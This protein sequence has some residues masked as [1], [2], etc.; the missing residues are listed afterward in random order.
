[1]KPLLPTSMNDEELLYS[2]ALTRI[3][4]LGLAGMRKLWHACGNATDIFRRRMELPELVTGSDK[5]VEALD[6]PPA[7]ERARHELEFIRKNK[8]ACLGYNDAEYPSRL[9][10]CGDAPTLL[11]YKGNTPLNQ[12]KVIN[13]VG[14]RHATEYG[15]EICH[16][17]LRDL[18]QLCPEVLIVSGLAYGI[19]IH[20]HRAALEY[21]F[22]TIGVLAHGLDRIYPPS[23]RH[24]AVQMVQQ[25]GLLTEFM[26]ETN[27]DR[28]NF[29][30][31]NRIV[32]SMCDA[33]IVVESAAKGGALITADL[34]EGYH[35]DCFAFPGR[36]YDPYSQ[37]CN[38]LIR[39]NRAALIQSAEEFVK[40]MCWDTG[41]T[42]PQPIQRQLFP[43]LTEEEEQIARTLQASPDG[44]PINELAMTSTL[45]VNKLSALLFEMEIKGVI[46][47]LPG[48]RYKTLL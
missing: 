7:F 43:D 17:F 10:E 21:G 37:G 1:M 23:H 20:A 3:P 24:T 16:N 31:R 48:N 9:R 47:A 19:D 46:Q 12:L 36:L 33:T 41:N 4:G 22:P 39:D 11:F 30:M 27:P 35:R 26:S 2:L 38:A 40:A 29:V 5:L 6:C 42:I 25:G 13:L 44:L 45:P 32:A 18:R 8:I 28:Q 14:T 15:K 34:A